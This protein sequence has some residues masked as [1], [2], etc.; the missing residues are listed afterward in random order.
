MRIRNT[1]T[2]DVYVLRMDCVYMYII[3]YK[4]MIVNTIIFHSC[5]IAI[6]ENINHMQITVPNAIVEYIKNTI[7]RYQTPHLHIFRFY[8]TK[9]RKPAPKVTFE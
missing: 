2:S 8:L 1:H 3:A 5:V 7:F 9:L 4:S 6:S